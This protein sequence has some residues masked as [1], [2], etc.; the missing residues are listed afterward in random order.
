MLNRLTGKVIVVAG[1]GGIG[2]ALAQRSAREGASVVL[3]DIDPGVA[4]SVVDEIVAAGGT[5]VATLLDGADDAS[6]KDIIDL[7]VS[8]FGALDSIHV[9]FAHMADGS[10]VADI[11]ELDMQDFDDAM[12]VNVRGYVLCTRHAI[13]AMLAHGGDSIVYTT[14]NAS[15]VAEPVRVACG[16]SKAAIMP[17]MRSVAQRFGPEGIRANAIAPGVI[18]HRR[19]EEAMPEE[20]KAAFMGAT[21]LKT[22]LCRPEDI[23]A[24]AALLMSEEG[25][26]I[27]GQVIP[28]EGGHFMR[29]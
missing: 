7:A 25:A 3:G 14:S 22:R 16:M 1:A 11:L 9:N 15:Y 18:L 12:R 20:A 27:P 4:E 28:V 29:P 17:M 10:K 8:R 26:F 24:V 21:A 19:M 6:S 2:N 23:A 13:P 5:A